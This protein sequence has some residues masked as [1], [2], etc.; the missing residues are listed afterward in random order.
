MSRT[1]SHVPIVPCALALALA[2]GACATPEKSVDATTAPPIPR[3]WTDQFHAPAVLIA[4]EIR[5]EGPQG[6]LEHVSTRPDPVHHERVEKTVPQGFLQQ[7]SVLP[8]SGEVE[9]QGQLDRLTVVATQRLIVLER[10]GPH[11]VTVTARG[12]AY[13][14]DEKSGEEK[15]GETLSLVGKIAR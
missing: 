1:R 4:T 5:I 6:L 2:L 10:P 9:I 14:K 7:I 15:R 13:W 11:D 12:D 8:D 3:A